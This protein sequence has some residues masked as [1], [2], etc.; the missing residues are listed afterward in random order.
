MFR[1]SIYKTPEQLR[2]MV[3]PGLATAASLVAA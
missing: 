3:E 1:S 2:L